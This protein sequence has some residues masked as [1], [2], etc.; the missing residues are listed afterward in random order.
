MAT[1][2]AADPGMGTGGPYWAPIGG[3]D[4]TPF[5]TYHEGGGLE[6]D[7]ADEYRRH[8]GALHMSYPLLAATLD[9]MGGSYDHD[10]RR[11]DT[12]AKLRIEGY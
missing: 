8:A 9:S 3:P 2:L 6:R 12:Q 7:L 1:R 4:C 5:D 11:E 10:A